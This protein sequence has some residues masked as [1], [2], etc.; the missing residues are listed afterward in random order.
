MKWFI[1]LLFALQA[2]IALANWATCTSIGLCGLNPNLDV[3]GPGPVTNLRQGGVAITN[4]LAHTGWAIAIPLIGE[5]VGG[6][7]GKWIAGLSWIALS[8]I[9]ESLFHAPNNPSQ[10]YPSEVRTDLIT[11]IVPT[12]L[13]LIF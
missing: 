5:K 1:T 8:L 4:A 13:V 9:Q 3:L 7:K 12:I 11:R 6:K 10:S 2:P